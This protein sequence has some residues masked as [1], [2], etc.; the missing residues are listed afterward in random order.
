MENAQLRTPLGQLLQELG[1]ALGLRQ[2]QVLQPRHV[3]NVL[4]AFVRQISHACDAT[5]NTQADR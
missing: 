3:A 4:Q 5:S 1:G 2:A